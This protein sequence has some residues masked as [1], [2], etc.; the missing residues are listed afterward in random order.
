MKRKIWNF[1]FVLALI[2]MLLVL[3]GCSSKNNEKSANQISDNNKHNQE[4]F[5]VGENL[6]EYGIYEWQYEKSAA[7]IIDKE[8]FTT[9]NYET[10]EAKEYKFKIEIC[11]FGLENAT[12]KTPREALVLYNEDGEIVDAFYPQADYVIHHY[13]VAG[14]YQLDRQITMTEL[15]KKVEENGVKI[16]FVEDTKIKEENDSAIQ[17]ITGGKGF[18][19]GDYFVTYGIYEFQKE[20][21]IGNYENG[22]YV[23]KKVTITTTLEIYTNKIIVKNTG[24]E[25]EECTY[26]IEEYNYSN[27]PNMDPNI[28]KGIV[29]Y[30]GPNEHGGVYPIANNKLTNN[31]ENEMVF[32]LK[33]AFTDD[34]LEANL[35]AEEEKTHIILKD[36]K[37]R[38]GLYLTLPS[39]ET[40]AISS[41]S[42]KYRISNEVGT[43]SINENQINLENGMVLTVIA[44]NKFT[45]N[46]KT[47]T[48]DQEY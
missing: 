15:S 43:F 31:K 20:E 24:E 21:D 26:K 17:N 37:L 11:N 39:I 28:H 32:T 6:M 34:E 27:R 38:N 23:S 13:G 1:I 48:L 3:T 33:K 22:K 5:Y 42:G 7:V 14:V 8:K 44:D 29:V 2:M 25:D 30:E 12:N 41:T 47:Y 9:V 46:N 19:I 4:P 36:Y 35:R 18:Q 16:H 45:C 10:G 40:L